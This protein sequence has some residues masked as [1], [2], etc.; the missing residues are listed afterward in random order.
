MSSDTVLQVFLAAAA[1]ELCVSAWLDWFNMRNVFRNAASVPDCFQGSI[2][3]E[4]WRKA[5][6]YTL[7]QSRLGLVENAFDTAVIAAFVLLG[8]F[9]FF[10]RIVMA[11]GWSAQL[12]GLLYFALLGTFFAFLS[13]PFRLYSQFVIEA[14][15]GFNKM[16]LRL[17]ILDQIKAAGIGAAIGA[18]TLLGLL[19]FMETAGDVWWIW[20]ASLV[21]ALTALMQVIYPALIAPVFNRFTPL[22]DGMLKDEV[23]TLANKVR[24]RMAGIYQMDASRRTRHGNAYLVG[25][26][27]GRRIVLFDTLI[28]AL[29]VRELVAVLAHE[30]GHWKQGHVARNMAVAAALQFGAFYVLNWL[31]SFA[32]FYEAFGFREPQPYRALAVFALCHGPFTFWLTPLLAAWSRRHEYAADRFAVDA[33]GTP[34]ALSSALLKL[35]RDNLANLAPHPWHSFFHH[36]HPTLPERLAAIVAAGTDHAVR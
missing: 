5:A 12:T 3:P 13:S 30:M 7:A 6:Q 14:R 2:T 16:T 15:F 27:A 32:T 9:P 31:M 8:G 10:D 34:E 11:A 22:E 29:G 17:W 19:W 35:S 28:Q 25:F 21:F 26:G 24:F 20:G 1:L 4:S 36:T 18:P 23:T 33:T